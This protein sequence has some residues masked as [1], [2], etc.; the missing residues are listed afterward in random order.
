ML[1]DPILHQFIH[2]FYGYGSFAADTWFLGMEE[3]GG[4]SLDEVSRRLAVWQARGG[5]ELED[6]CGYH[7][8]LYLGQFF[9]EPV[10]LQR[11]WAQLCRMVLV[12]RGEPADLQA[13]KAYQKDRLGR[14][15]GETCLMELLPLPSPGTD[16]WF[17]A[18]WSM[19]PFLTS[20]STY[21]EQVLPVRIKNLKERIQQHQPK[22]VIFYGMGYWEHWA[23]VAEATFTRLAPDGFGWAKK[24]DTNFLIIQHPAAKGVSNDYFERAGKLLL[25]ARKI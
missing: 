24:N 3:G 2:S 21:Q 4:E 8:A 6:V 10:K 25:A 5:Q 16:R 19:L 17:Y 22:F 7:D 9:R 13:V 1:N 20:R 12:S 23:A 18:D 14:P 15:A 11:T